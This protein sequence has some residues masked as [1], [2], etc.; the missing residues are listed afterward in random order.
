MHFPPD[1][2]FS[3]FA[4]TFRRQLQVTA[5]TPPPDKTP[6]C[7][8]ALDAG[9]VG[10]FTKQAPSLSRRTCR[11]GV[12]GGCQ[13]LIWG[14][15]SSGEILGS[16]EMGGWLSCWPRFDVRYWV[17][18]GRCGRARP[19]ACSQIWPPGQPPGTPVSHISAFGQP[20]GGNCGQ[21]RSFSVSDDQRRSEA[22]LP[23]VSP[24]HHDA[25]GTACPRTGQCHRLTLS[26][27]CYCIPVL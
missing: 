17:G 15:R 14:R 13:Y 20:R 12:V 23:P 5:G 27:R 18:R 1:P 6:P 24:E 8:S 2:S 9:L 4:V 25:G 3:P 7:R 26:W 21:Q 22:T 11:L 10:L 16:L 19:N